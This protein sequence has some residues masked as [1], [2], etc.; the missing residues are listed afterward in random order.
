MSYQPIPNIPD[1]RRVQDAGQYFHYMAQFVGFTPDDSSAIRQSALVVEKHLPAIIGR[2]YTNLLQ[3]PPTR[4]F[5]LKR[6]GSLDEDYL[7]LRMFHQANFWRRA[8]GGEY[9]DEF[10]HFVDYVGRAH[11]S[12]GADPR[13][14]IAERYVIGMVGFVQH[15]IIEA[16]HREL[17]E[18]DPDLQL[19]ASKAWNK[20]CMV[21]LEMLARAYGEEREIDVFEPLLA[22]DPE[23][24]HQIAINSYEK[25]LGMRRD[26]S[27]RDVPVAQEAEIEDGERKIVEVDGISIG[28]FH[29]KGKWYALRNSCLHRGGPVCTGALEGDHLVCPWHGYT[30][31]VTDGHLLIDSSAHLE[32][33][34]VILRDGQIYLRLPAVSEF[35]PLGPASKDLAAAGGAAPAEK[36]KLKENEFFI[37]ELGPGKAKQV[38]LNGVPVAVFNIEGQFYA[39][40]NECTH[41]GGPLSE[42]EIE[43]HTVICPWHFSCFDL[44]TGAATC[45]P[46][47]EAVKTF[48]VVVEGEVGRVE[49]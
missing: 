36:P 12:H 15:A 28:V 42:G 5:F 43:G 20:L 39:T 19:R 34:P 17:H 23:A 49:E 31:D 1:P 6:D 18:Y 47:R 14:Y 21:I 38:R 4:K 16:L 40:H 41:A 26:L 46:A 33:Y 29:H 9:D 3:Y 25:G 45:G 22:V 27:T 48:K 2:F 30:Y 10:A 11:T 44:T 8:A 13:L 37:E 35:H 7:Q 32:M 24:V